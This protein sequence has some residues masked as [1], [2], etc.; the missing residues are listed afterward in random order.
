SFIVLLPEH[1]R[2]YRSHASLIEHELRASL[3]D[4][5]AARRDAPAPHPGSRRSR[6]F[7]IMPSVTL[8]PDE[9]GGN[10]R[11]SVT[12]ADRVGLLHDLARVF[13]RHHVSL[14]IAKIMTVD[15][16]V[17]AVFILE[18]AGL[19]PRRGQIQFDR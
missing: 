11:L 7:P 14:K 4:R 5:P 2:D 10:W 9:L 18:G 17:A 12:A 19:K 15:T 3:T 1:D 13:A 16:G 8:H 6:A